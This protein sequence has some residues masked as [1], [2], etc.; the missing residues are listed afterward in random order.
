MV[1]WAGNFIVV[2][3]ALDVLPPVGFAAIRFPIAGLTLVTLLRIREGSIGL[4]RRD[5]L[6]I[7][8][9]GVV[10]FGAYQ[11]LWPTGLQSISAGDS[12]LLIAAT[13]VVTVLL[14]VVAGSDILT[15]WKLVGALVSFV[16]VGVV[17]AGGEGLTLTKSL[18]GDLITMVAAVCWAAYTAF[19]ARV[20]R[21]YSPLRTT[22]WALAGGLLVL[23]PIGG[24]QL[25]QT[26]W[27]RVGPPVLLAVLYSATLSGGVSNAIVFHGVKVLGPSRTTAFQF[28]VP[29]IAVVLAAIFLGEPIRFA[30][31]AGGAVI[32]LGVAI[33]RAETFRRRRVS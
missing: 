2:K 28:L 30:Q 1:F 24:A 25:A 7:M 16:G 20:L 23:A 3:A 13:P 10:G 21:R 26:D 17:I 15:R 18:V 11:V 27:S 22:T 9:L 12:A 31:V 19:G 33:A 14:A 8:L 4:P 32:L 29:A 5:V 6:P